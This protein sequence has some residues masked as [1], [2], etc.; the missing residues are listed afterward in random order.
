MKLRL[1]LPEDA[2][3]V[4]SLILDALR[5]EKP[6]GDSL[7]NCCHENKPYLRVLTAMIETV[8]GIVD[9]WQVIL[10][11]ESVTHDR[12]TAAQIVAVG[13]WQIFP[14]KKESVDPSEYR[15]SRRSHSPTYT[16]STANLVPLFRNAPVQMTLTRLQKCPDV[17]EATIS[18][19]ERLADMFDAIDHGR[20]CAL[21]K[22]SRYLFLR[23]LATHPGHQ[24]AGHAAALVKWGI[25]LSRK[26][27][28]S[29]GAF[30]GPKGYIMLSGMGFEDC[31]LAVLPTEKASQDAVA[32]L[33]VA[34]PMN[35]VSVMDGLKRCISA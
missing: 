17:T 24:R 11:E 27:K 18:A 21:N 9:T 28:L 13:V 16:C 8:I 10:A 14:C 32:K 22:L 4:A 23:V 34:R 1:A 26:Y 7:P 33:M 25:E 2:P 30:C 19:T 3:T 15:I 35:R 29:I 6:W 12:V 20:Y 5:D 31:G